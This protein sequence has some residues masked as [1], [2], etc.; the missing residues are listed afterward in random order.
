[1]DS[2][3][4]KKKML[5]VLVDRKRGLTFL[6]RTH[7]YGRIHFLYPAKVPVYRRWSLVRVDIS[8]IILFMEPHN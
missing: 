4:V 5:F 7:Y 2:F 1:M 3:R 6:F 8:K